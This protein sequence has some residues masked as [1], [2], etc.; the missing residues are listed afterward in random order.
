M[1]YIKLIWDFLDDN[2]YEVKRRCVMGVSCC[3]LVLVSNKILLLHQY[4]EALACQN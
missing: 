4:H 3:W 1:Q 2:D